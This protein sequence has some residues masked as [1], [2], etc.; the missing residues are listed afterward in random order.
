MSDYPFEV[1]ASDGTHIDSVGNV[2]SLDSVL[3]GDLSS[4]DGHPRIIHVPHGMDDDAARIQYLIDINADC[5]GIPH[6]L[7]ERF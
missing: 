2:E 3:Y 6:D 1:Y 5:F 7:I 4:H